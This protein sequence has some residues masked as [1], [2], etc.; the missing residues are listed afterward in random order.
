MELVV[1]KPIWLYQ[2][3]ITI[4]LPDGQRRPWNEATQRFFTSF[5]VA[6]KPPA[7]LVLRRLCVVATATVLWM[8]PSHRQPH[9]WSTISGSN[10]M[11]MV[12]CGAQIQQNPHRPKQATKSLNG[13]TESCFTDT[14]YTLKSTDTVLFVFLLIRTKA[15]MLMRIWLGY[16]ST[17]KLEIQPLQDFWAKG[18]MQGAAQV[19]ISLCE[20]WMHCLD[21]C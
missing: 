14:S 20:N 6:N 19:Q 1:S 12:R 8:T 5:I 17:I 3:L 10:R 16:A 21:G 11:M 4:L 7:Q 9:I 13:N 2:S 18:S 15:M